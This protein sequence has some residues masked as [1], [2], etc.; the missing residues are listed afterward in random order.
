[1][2]NESAIQYIKQTRLGGF[3]D[4]EIRKELE[5]AGWQNS[6]ID[7]AF[8]LASAPEKLKPPEQVP[9]KLV[10]KPLEK[11]VEKPTE[12][13]AVVQARI[14]A[15]MN[16]ISKNLPTI[17]EA[18]PIIKNPEPPVPQRADFM[19]V[20]KG[21]VRQQIESVR[22]QE[23]FQ[24]Q[25]ISQKNVIENVITQKSQANTFA[26]PVATTSFATRRTKIFISVAI[27]LFIS[28]S[29]AGAGY[30]YYSVNIYPGNVL[31]TALAALSNMKSYRYDV[32]FTVD[33]KENPSKVSDAVNPF[34]P[35]VGSL[36]LRALMAPID[37]AAYTTA[38]NKP[39]SKFSIGIKGSM[40]YI[41]AK[42][43]KQQMIVTLKT[44]E[45]LSR[46]IELE[47][48]LVG[49]IHYFQFT[50]L[51]RIPDELL[52][53]NSVPPIDTASFEKKWVS[54]NP[55][56]L[57]STYNEYIKTLTAKDPAFGEFLDTG[58]KKSQKQLSEEA[59][60][61][62]GGL[63]QKST[64]INWDQKQ[65]DE[66]LGSTPM[67]RFKGALNKEAYI[68]FVEELAKEAGGNISGAEL[69]DF[70]KSLD[71]IGRVEFNIWVAKK[72]QQVAQIT[73]SAA[74]SDPENLGDGIAEFA[75]LVKLSDVD[76]PVSVE[77][78]QD[79]IDF[80][81]VLDSAFNTVLGG[82]EDA[83]EKARDARR[84][85]DMR[86]IQIALELYYDKKGFY[87]TS[88]AVLAPEF[89]AAIPKDP[90]TQKS[91][92]YKYISERKYLISARLENTQSPLLKNDARPGDL[93]FDIA[94]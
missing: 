20:M 15:K 83:R 33:V 17:I 84:I 40:D 49:G 56:T 34:L 42:N 68:A 43:P 30:W 37:E 8:S 22:S 87:P 6:D 4:A 5:K 31:Q 3:G 80:K 78:P 48:R 60:T 45:F 32:E 39:P 89:M 92:V 69:D 59:I 26:I 61:R 73:G 77:A 90:Q 11:P 54:F 25:P 10:E 27:F 47:N 88:L 63:W 21:P 28:A 58:Q 79:A 14:P 50:E 41:D 66:F 86:Q 70:R 18:V 1:M 85:A 7:A 71:S 55:A 35:R 36:F 81:V 75:F 29:V 76:K 38:E 44:K 72:T 65:Y 46:N 93:Y 82:F 9:I 64:F 53:G 23:F 12:K 52:R 51:P 16:D 94:P 2:P 74:I 91:Y 62:L 24:T 57:E 13:P 19:P 67:Y